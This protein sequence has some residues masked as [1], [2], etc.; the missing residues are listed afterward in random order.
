MGSPKHL[1]SGDWQD[2][3]A[4]A[5]ARRRPVA[6]TPPPDPQPTPVR[7]RPRPARPPRTRRRPRV[8]RQEMRRWA[9]AGGLALLVGFVATSLANILTRDDS[10]PAGSAAVS[11]GPATAWMGARLRTS[12][13]GGALIESLTPGSPAGAAGLAPGDLIIGVDNA[14]VTSADDVTAALARHRP[15]DVVAVAARRGG[16]GFTAQVTLESRPAGGP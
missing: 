14:S 16:A 3:S 13:E 11:H 12:R 4:A 9:I 10:E 1:W 6:E 15:G 2:E 7:E 5:A 8:S